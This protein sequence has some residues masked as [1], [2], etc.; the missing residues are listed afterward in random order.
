MSHSNQSYSTEKTQKD[1]SQLRQQKLRES[2]D[3][4]QLV[5][6]ANNDGIWDWD[7]ETDVLFFS[8]RWQAM[9]G[10]EDKEL[11]NHINTWKN[12]LH[13]DDRERAIEVLQEYLEKKIPD[14][15]VEFRLRCQDGT[16]KWILSRGQALWDKS[17]K[18]RRMA[19]SHTDISD[20]K[21]EQTLLRSLIDC[22]PDAIFYKN[23]GGIYLACNNAFEEFV[24]RKATE[25][26]GLTDFDIF[27]HPAA[28]CYREQECLMMAQAT[29]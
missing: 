8:T 1:T 5:L 15:S 12:L 24:G 3:R 9:L 10:Y 26:I 13:P 7:L 2:E 14:Y 4:W 18:P 20:R 11:D 19:G 17:G 6:R 16:Y 28:S 29:S 23:Q 27:A 22:I 21:Q 25:I